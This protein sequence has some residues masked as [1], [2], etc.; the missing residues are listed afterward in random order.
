MFFALKS[1]SCLICFSCFLLF[2]S[3]DI[4]SWLF[5]AF[6][7]ITCF[8]LTNR[9]NSPSEIHSCLNLSDLT[10]SSF[11]LALKPVNSVK[12][13]HF[14]RYVSSSYFVHKHLLLRIFVLQ[15]RDV[16]LT[17]SK[18]FTV[19]EPKERVSLGKV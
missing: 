3:R 10:F 11:F 14:V 5:V 17:E 13:V 18:V 12:P 19:S 7:S 6:I 16:F 4:L 15:N 2:G 9:V 8:I 1:R